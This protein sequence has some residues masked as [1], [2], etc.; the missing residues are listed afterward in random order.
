[1]SVAEIPVID[2]ADI[3][4]R[5]S[6]AALEDVARKIRAA[7]T[8]T[9]FFYIANHGVPKDL[10]EEIFEANR[11]FHD[12]PLEEKMQVRRNA[13]HRGYT[14]LASSTLKSSARFEAARLPNVLEA[15]N[16]RNE[17]SPDDPSYKKE[18]L[19]G[20]NEWPADAEFRGAVERYVAAATALGVR[21]L[22][23]IAV[24]AGQHKDFFKSF[25][26]NPTT[27]LRLI[28][29][30]PQPPSRPQDQFGI[31]PH[32]D[33]GFLTILAQDSVGGLQVQRIDG[34]WIDAS[35]VPDTFI[36]NMGD[37]LARWTN[38]HFNSTPHRVISPAKSTARYS[39]AFF[40]DPELDTI[41]EC[42]PEF[43]KAGQPAKYEPI[44]YGDYFSMRLDANH[45]RRLDAEHTSREP[46][47]A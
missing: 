16:I 31:F 9:G 35:Y 43:V 27:N 39:V 26:G 45:T 36:I 4:D 5:G 47:Q 18:S 7:C 44:R 11:R 6:S 12:R 22:E 28:H 40:F 15:F 29:Y 21:L 25:F 38:E 2:I 34:S 14:P 20:P 41:V 19:Q 30:P 32:T 3:G 13:W 17:V 37:T 42:L 8:G 33:Y 24:A 10:M 1:M 23:P 46:A